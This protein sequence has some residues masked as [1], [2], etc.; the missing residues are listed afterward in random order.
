MTPAQWQV[1]RSGGR[2]VITVPGDLDITSTGGIGQAVA[3]ALR[4][5][6]TEVVV[7]TTR[8]RYCGGS[9]I[10][11]LARAQRR[12]AAAGAR[13]LVTASPAVLA[14]MTLTDAGQA[15]EICAQ[16]AESGEPV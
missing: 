2:A 6:A 4:A 9:G 11:A 16:P 12:A 1:S 13:L 7:D 10:T 14:A 8:A 3:A 5:G 15:L